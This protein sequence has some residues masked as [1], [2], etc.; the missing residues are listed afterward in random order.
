MIK[1][2]LVLVLSL[3]FLSACHH[4]TE[5]KVSNEN[6]TGEIINF[7]TLQGKWQSLDDEKSVINFS[8]RQQ[9]VFYDNEEVISG[10]FKLYDNYPV[11]IEDVENKTGEYI[12]V[13]S[14]ENAFEYRI[15]EINEKT[16]TLSYLP[17][18][19]TLRYERTQ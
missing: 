3:F 2:S 12:V 15:L 11:G 14:R 19:N 8:G 4:A 6:K 10:N 16:L 13:R 5:E 9:K 1:K 7:Q 18:G 17:R